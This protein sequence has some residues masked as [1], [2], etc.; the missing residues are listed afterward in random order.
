MG[1]L[2][3]SAPPDIEARIYRK[4]LVRIIPIIMLGMF[5]SYID[6]AN[7]GV[8]AAP[9]SQDLGLTAA[10]FGLAAGLFYI[11]YCFFEIPSNLSLI[12]I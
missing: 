1:N 4:M 12:H 9:M 10:S 11:G 2:T 3:S 5:I 7:I 8:L 6:R